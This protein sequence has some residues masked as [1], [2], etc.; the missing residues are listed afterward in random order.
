MLAAL[1]NMAHINNIGIPSFAR[2]SKVEKTKLNSTEHS[3][4]PEANIFSSNKEIPQFG[5]LCFPFPF[6][7]PPRARQ[8]FQPQ[9]T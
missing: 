2:E 5:E 9:A 6:F 4:S 3:P 8:P 1:K 7:L